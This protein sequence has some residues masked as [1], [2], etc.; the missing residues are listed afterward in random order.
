MSNAEKVRELICTSTARDSAEE[1]KT[2][3]SN[4]TNIDLYD[5]NIGDERVK[6]LA[7]ALA[8]N[9]TITTINLSANRIGTE[10][11]KSL[12]V[13]LAKNTT[14]TNI[15]LSDNNIGAEGTKSLG[16]ALAKNTTITNINLSDNDIGAEGAK[17]LA[18]ALAT[19][20]TITT[21]D[22]GDNDIGPEGAKSLVDTLV[23]NTTITTI[24]LP[25]RIFR[26]ESCRA[27]KKK[28]FSL[29]NFDTFLYGGP[30]YEIDIAVPDVYY[31][32][33]VWGRTRNETSGRLPL[34]TAAARSLTW[35]DVRQILAVNMPVIYDVDGLTGLPVF[36]LAAVGPQSNIESVY[37]LL[38]E[39][40]SALCLMNKQHQNTSFCPA[41]NKI[42]DNCIKNKWQK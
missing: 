5:I 14:I 40:P 1:L 34:F 22:L 16:A 32:M 9:T 38:K 42:Q 2:Y 19:N 37:H 35:V 3:L 25:K 21:I 17:S 12:A 10:G 29:I 6:V 20:T 23:S 30:R 39:Y 33:K 8:K 31:N 11:T 18:D 15:N 28:G 4:I 26:D 36:M 13:A 24:T 41:I 7:V 27:L